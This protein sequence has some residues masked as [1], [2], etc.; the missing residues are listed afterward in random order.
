[1]CEINLN[2][3]FF[4]SLCWGV[5]ETTKIMSSDNEG[6]QMDDVD[7]DSAVEADPNTANSGQYHTLTTTVIGCITNSIYSTCKYKS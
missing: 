1:M 2:F 7:I 3:I 4:F 5:G 6:L